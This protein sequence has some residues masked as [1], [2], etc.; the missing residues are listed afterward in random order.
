M[1]LTMLLLTN[2]YARLSTLGLLL[3]AGSAAFGQA[4]NGTATVGA[5]RKLVMV[6]AVYPP[7]INATGHRLGPGIDVDIAQE[8]LKR[9]GYSME[10]KI[11]PWKRA[12][13]MLENGSADFTTTI[14]KQ[15]DRNAYLAW[16]P[17]YRTGASYRFYSRKDASLSITGL[18]DLKDKRLGAVSGFHYPE[19][20]VER[21]GVYVVRGQNLTS[22]IRMLEAQRSDV[23]V[24]TSIAGAWEIREL[25]MQGQLKSHPY[26][27]VAESRNY[28]AFSRK[29]DFAA[30]LAAMTSALSEMAKDGTIARIA[31]KYEDG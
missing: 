25:G 16:T 28:M 23:M 8:A 18:E 12:L 31:R 14:S 5:G 13:L 17:S 6:N 3:L 19:A 9:A 24:V 30:P 7:F 10:L 26:E 27:Y 15:D 22:V 1:N 21:E 11:V 4:F 20:I 2:R 29:T